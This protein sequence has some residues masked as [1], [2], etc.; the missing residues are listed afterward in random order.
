M[1]NPAT[2]LCLQEVLHNQLIDI[3]TALN[4]SAEIG[5]EWKY[6]GVGRDGMFSRSASFCQSS[7][8]PRVNLP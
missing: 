2:F 8:A 3:L 5:G 4:Q 6:I 7:W 1:P